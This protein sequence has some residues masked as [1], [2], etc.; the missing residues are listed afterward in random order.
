[1]SVA[2]LDALERGH[3][4]KWVCQRWREHLDLPAESNDLHALCGLPR[5]QD[6]DGILLRFI[7]MIGRAHAEGVVNDDQQEVSRRILSGAVNER[8]SKG[9]HEKQDEGKSQREED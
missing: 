6:R 4:L 5:V 1:M 7:Q 3:R 9:Q 2:G 8:I